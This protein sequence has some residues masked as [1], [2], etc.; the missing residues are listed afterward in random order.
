PHSAFESRNPG[1]LAQRAS[2]L[3]QSREQ[4]LPAVGLRG[5]RSAE[6]EPVVH[7]L[8]FE[9]YRE[10]ILAARSL[11]AAEQLG[12]LLGQQAHGDEP[13]LTAVREKDVGKRRRENRAEAVLAERPNGVL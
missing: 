8:L 7:A 10:P 12:D 6:P 5:K 11:M 9:V 2:D 4:H 13:V 1:F 3:I